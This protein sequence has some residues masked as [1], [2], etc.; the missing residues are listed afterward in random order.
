[1]TD[2]A[3]SGHGT[4]AIGEGGTKITLLQTGDIAFIEADSMMINQLPG[5]CLDGMAGNIY[6]RARDKNG[7]MEARPLMGRLSRSAASFSRRSVRYAGE[8]AG[9]S[10]TL[11]V[12]VTDGAWFFTVGLKADAGVDIRG[13]DLVYAQDIGLGSREHVRSNEVYNAQYLDHKVFQTEQGYTVCTRQNQTQSGAFPFLQQG[14]LNAKAASFS[15]DGYPFYGL[16]YKFDNIPAGL[17]AP[18]LNNRLYQYEFAF[19]AL[20]TE[21]LEGSSCEVIFYCRFLPNL[22]TAIEKPLPVEGIAAL[23]QRAVEREAEEAYSA[24]PPLASAFDV[25]DT[26]C[27]PPLS[28]EELS[29]FFPVRRL[30]ERDRGK[31]LSFFT[32]T[33]AHVATQEKER[34]V[35]RSHGNI[36][37][38]GNICGKD[39]FTREDVLTTTQYMYGVFNS[40]L[41]LGNTS[42]NRIISCCRNGLNVQKCSGQRLMVRIDGRY[43]LLAMPAVFEMGISYGR[44]LYKIEGETFSDLLEIQV[45][46]AADRPVIRFEARSLNK[47]QYDFLLLTAFTGGVDEYGEGAVILKRED[48]RIIIR[49][50]EKAASAKAYPGLE[51][52]ITVDGPFSLRDDSL[53]PE[54]NLSALEAF[55]TDTFAYTL[56][57]RLDAHAGPAASFD[58]AFDTE[59]EILAY[60]AALREELNGFSLSLPGNGQAANTVESFNFLVFWYAHNARIHF[61]S[62]HGLEQSGG[63]AWGTRDVCQG[64][65]EYFLSTRQYARARAALVKVYGAQFYDDGAWPQWFMF[66]R[67]RAIR[68]EHSH[69]DVI[70]W[71]L[72]ALTDYAGATGDYSILEEK[73]PYALRGAGKITESVPIREHAQKQLSAIKAALIPGTALMRYGGGD[74]DDTLQP[75]DPSLRDKMASGWTNALLYQ[76]L[77][78][79]S[80]VFAPAG[81]MEREA[82]DAA[83]LAKEV[84]RDFYRYF[85]ADNVAA[86]FV[87]FEP[88][89][90][91]RLLLHPKDNETGLHYRLLSQTRGIIAGLFEPDEVPARIALIRRRLLHPDGAR[92]MDAPCRYQGGVRRFFDRAETAANFGREIGLQY[93]HSHIRFVEAMAKAGEAEEAWRGLMTV[94]PVLRR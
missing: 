75:Y 31:L 44:W 68:D 84:R 91:T 21:P 10:Y 13:A 9:F 20:Q 27:S 79:F 22:A 63:A 15:V 18:A 80:T 39:G 34:L 23:Y 45:T 2:P 33:G 72:K 87:I 56:Q 60:S 3:A 29:E 5:N 17:G 73:A 48:N 49:H 78:S 51:F 28:G 47:K 50:N 71:P 24:F 36:L 82:A 40:S 65:F 70:L 12:Y 90:V 6:L 30:E 25:H 37:I 76:I 32:G 83:R 58:T 66:D 42:F 74:W 89:G 46:A 61:V 1:M 35:E 54:C 4:R 93:V 8:A 77:L 94:S 85:I 67:Y 55:G 64:P 59:K 14:L 16:S 52:V 88:D 11:T 43:R 62:P 81:S 57:G 69:G 26:Y 19:T 7:N 41:A 53:L 92:L 38:T 86:G